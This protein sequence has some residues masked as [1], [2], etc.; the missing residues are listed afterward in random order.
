MKPPCLSASQYLSPLNALPE[1]TS[2]ADNDLHPPELAYTYH[3]AAIR[4]GR[5]EGGGGMHSP[6]VAANFIGI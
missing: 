6:E 3:R 4:A 5:A 2:Y 1:C